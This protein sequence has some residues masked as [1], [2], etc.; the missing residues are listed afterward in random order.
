MMSALREENIP[1]RLLSL[2]VDDIRPITSNVISNETGVNPKT[3]GEDYYGWIGAFGFIKFHLQNSPQ[4]DLLIEGVAEC[5]EGGVDYPKLIRDF[6]LNNS[7]VKIKAAFIGYSKNFQ[8]PR[9]TNRGYGPNIEV[10]KSRRLKERVEKL[11]F[12]NY[13]YFDLVDSVPP[14]RCNGEV[15]QLEERDFIRNAGKVIDYLLA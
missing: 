8:R 10:D 5:E 7:E 13:K 4:C 1:R 3:K 14:E 9:Y 15:L 2:S 6:E 11:N 12:P